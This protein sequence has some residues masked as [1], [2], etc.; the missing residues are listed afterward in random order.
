MLLAAAMERGATTV[1]ELSDELARQEKER[2]LKKQI[3]EQMGT[4]YV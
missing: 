3:A 2:E 1:G 4:K